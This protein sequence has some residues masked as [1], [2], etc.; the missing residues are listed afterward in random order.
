MT[1][2]FERAVSLPVPAAEA[3]AWHTRPGAFRR[4]S[5][6]WKDVR[7]VG[8]QAP[9]TP[10]ARQVM[11]VGVGPL[12]A[13]WEAEIRDVV[14]GLSFRDVQ[15]RG[16]FASWEHEHRVEPD[17]DRASTLIDRVAYALPLAPL[18][19]LVAGRHV[20]R[21][22]ERLFAF[23][24]RVTQRDL[25]RHAE[26]NAAPRTVL[27]SGASGLVG[28]ALVAFLASGGHAVRTLVRRDVRRPDEFR[29]DP[30]TGAFDRRALAGVDAVVH[31]AGENVGAPRWNDARKR[32]IRESRL[33]G[34]ELLAREVGRAKDGPRVF[35]QASAIGFYGDRGEEELTEDSPSG[36]GFLPEVARAWE[37]V[38]AEHLAGVRRA[39]LRFGVVVTPEGGALSRMLPPFR[40]GAGGPVGDGR[41]WMSWV[42]LDDAVGAIDFALR[43]ERVDGAVN[44]VAPD[45]IRNRDFGR[46]LGSVLRRPAVL[47]LPAFAARAAFGEIADALLLASQR[48]LPKR[49]VELGFRFEDPTL[50]GA[51]RHCLGADSRSTS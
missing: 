20:A 34:T 46:V 3:F 37:S 24:H 16:P 51:L 38:G 50:D 26:G 33:L 12:E 43:D 5:P 10:G 14:A 13:T 47:P 35:V 22:V 6:P 32:A 19:P 45:P 29:W 11:K 1:R 41:Q 49:L 23:R 9:I 30:A 40:A 28:S 18:G 42:S 39:R 15:L 44:V 31:L 27:V 36:D 25:R 7:L 8:D 4:L 21:D 2:T 17:G 48:V